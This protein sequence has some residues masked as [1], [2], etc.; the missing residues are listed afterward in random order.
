MEPVCGNFG[1]P[2]APTLI[3]LIA[4]AMPTL[5]LWTLVHEGAHALTVSGRDDQKFKYLAP[6][7][8]ENLDPNGKR[9]TLIG[10]VGYTTKTP[11]YAG[12]RYRGHRHASV[13]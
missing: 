12:G 1:S 4:C 2:D 8:H 13:S 6:F 9:K 7:P 11:A 10:A 3:G 5:F